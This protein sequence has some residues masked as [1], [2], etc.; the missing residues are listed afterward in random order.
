M[1]YGFNKVKED[2]LRIGELGNCFYVIYFFFCI[3]IFINIIFVFD[4]KYRYKSD[5]DGVCI[6][7]KCVYNI[8][9]FFKGK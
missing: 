3:C 1:I 5:I 2:L 8:D 9:R 7:I 4:K 6:E